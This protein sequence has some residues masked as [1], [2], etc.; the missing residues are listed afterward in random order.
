MADEQTNI[1]LPAQL[2]RRLEDEAHQGRRTFTAEVV[3]RLEGSFV[4]QE[5][6]D[7]TQELER[8]RSELEHAKA[9]SQALEHMHSS[10]EFMQMMLARLVIDL[11]RAL[12]PALR[13]HEG[14]AIRAKLAQAILDKDAAAMA[15]AMGPMLDLPA[16]DVK[17]IS[18][19]MREVAEEI[20]EMS[21][22]HPTLSRDEV[23]GKVIRRRHG[24]ED[25]A[26]A[27]EQPKARRSR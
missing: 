10:G 7:Q 6:R 12:P 24:L 23:V 15:E 25:P 1:R 17:K 8:L 20:A 9:R 18:A 13:E 11:Y 22:R 19:E 26:A 3:S 27:P 21:R 5:Y 14:I 16:A 2:K 4:A